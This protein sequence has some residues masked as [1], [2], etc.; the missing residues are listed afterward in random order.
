MPFRFATIPFSTTIR[1]VGMWL[2]GAMLN[3]SLAAE[4]EPLAM[5]NQLRVLSQ[6]LTST[7][8]RSVLE[9]MIRNDLDAE[10]RRVFTPDNYV[11]FR[12]AQG[13]SE[14]VI[15]NRQLKS[16]VLSSKPLGYR[17]RLSSARRRR[18][19]VTLTLKKL[20]K[21]RA[22]THVVIDDQDVKSVANVHFRSGGS[23][24]SPA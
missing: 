18:D 14:K 3:Q 6:D 16:T 11:T 23:S 12:E 2:A 8:Y 20:S 17:H 15:Q 24:S 7:D 5:G 10:W 1:L 21:T 19:D 13:G 9:T 22:A 4:P